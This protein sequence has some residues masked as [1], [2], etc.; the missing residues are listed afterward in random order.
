M[1]PGVRS[2]FLCPGFCFHSIRRSGTIELEM[3]MLC[4]HQNAGS[5]GFRF[6]RGYRSPLNARLGKDYVESR[7]TKSY[8]KQK[9]KRQKGP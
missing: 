1:C 2:H 9:E 7:K 5:P 6:G 3:R 4:F 8:L